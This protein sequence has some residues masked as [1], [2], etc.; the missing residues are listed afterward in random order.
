MLFSCLGS[1][2]G[3]GFSFLL[4]FLC[5]LKFCFRF[6]QAVDHSSFT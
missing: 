1:S 2:N 5:F 6:M 3:D 4:L